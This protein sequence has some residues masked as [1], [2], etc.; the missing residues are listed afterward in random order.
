MMDLFKPEDFSGRHGKMWLSSLELAEVCAIANKLILERG[1][2][3]YLSEGLDQTQ[4]VWWHPG[5]DLKADEG[6]YEKKGII[7]LV[8]PTA[9]DTPEKVLRDWLKL[10]SGH[11]D[12][13]KDED[14]IRKRAERVL[15]FK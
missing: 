13:F 9:K 15:D 14:V 1:R 3:V 7:V 4:Q 8:E 2:I 11:A 10:E 5:P 12:Q 6:H